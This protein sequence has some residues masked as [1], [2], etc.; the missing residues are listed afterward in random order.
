MKII[1]FLIIF[2][3]NSTKATNVSFNCKH[4][5]NGCY[6]K[7]YTNSYY[8]KTTTNRFICKSLRQSSTLELNLTKCLKNHND[9]YRIYFRLAKSELLDRSFDMAQINQ[10]HILMFVEFRFLKGFDISAYGNE[11]VY[12]WKEMIFFIIYFSKF[13]FYFNHRLVT[14]CDN[15]NSTN[16]RM[17]FQVIH[18]PGLV[19][20]FI[21]AKFSKNQV[22]PSL[23]T[24]TRLHRID[25]ADSL[26]NSFYKKNILTF[27]KQEGTKINTVIKTLF[28]VK[29]HNIDIDETFLDKR[30]FKNLSRL[31][32]IGEI[33]S[34]QKGLFKSF[35]QMRELSIHGLFYIKLV[36]RDGIH[37]LSDFNS[38]V[39]INLSDRSSQ[40]TVNTIK[41]KLFLF[42]LSTA[43]PW[44]GMSYDEDSVRIKALFPDEDFCLYLD[45]PFEQAI[46][47]S[48]IRAYVNL[49][50]PCSFV[51]LIQYTQ[52][53]YDFLEPVNLRV[54]SYN[55]SMFLQKNLV[56]LTEIA[57]KC[58]FEKRYIL[59]VHF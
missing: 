17:L 49:A 54:Y 2:V 39:R 50:R 7:T 34:I 9:A 56:N 28:V 4:M 15:L 12:S 43:S 3:A 45:F 55:L 24:E 23:F 31:A 58:N 36:R 37:W 19:V 16:I 52:I 48:Y 42:D 14:S 38:E 10:Q 30:V 6:L 47:L 29:F 18:S 25:F 57:R 20:R 5:I 26:V 41:S 40:L 22:C 35:I 1:Y 32:L 11:A 44:H 46:V 8:D 53:Y 13:E 59:F 51:W 27:S 21:R 33:A